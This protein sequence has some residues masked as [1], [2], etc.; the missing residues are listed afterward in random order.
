MPTPEIAHT[1]H[2]YPRNTGMNWKRA[3]KGTRMTSD[4]GNP[5]YRILRALLVRSGKMRKEGY[6]FCL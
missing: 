2:Q 4:M 3:Q 1:I 6:D 5:L